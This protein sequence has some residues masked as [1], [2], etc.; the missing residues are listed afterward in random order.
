MVHLASLLALSSLA[1]LVLVVVRLDG[2][3]DTILFSPGNPGAGCG[4]GLYVL[5]RR[6]TG[7]FRNWSQPRTN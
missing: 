6:R 1:I 4:D 7:A 2:A 3:A 5:H